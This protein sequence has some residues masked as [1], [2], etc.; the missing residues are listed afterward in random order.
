MIPWPASHRRPQ[1]T[2]RQQ[3]AAIGILLAIGAVVAVGSWSLISS[4]ESYDGEGS[5]I[6]QIRTVSDL[7]AAERAIAGR[8]QWAERHRVLY[9]TMNVAMV[10]GMAAAVL[11]ILAKVFNL[12]GDDLDA[13]GHWDRRI[14]KRPAR[15]PDPRSF[16]RHHRDHTSS[17]ATISP[18]GGKSGVPSAAS[19]YSKI[20]PS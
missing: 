4:L 7:A 15:K 11:W 20:L 8:E 2:G 19:G 16:R 14:A 5:R 12:V 17:D 6:H 10:V 9:V 1:P 3:L 18:G 13:T